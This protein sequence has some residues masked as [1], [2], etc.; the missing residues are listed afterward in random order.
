MASDATARVMAGAV[1]ALAHVLEVALEFQRT[2][3]AIL[4]T[5]AS[6]QGSQK[7]Q[8]R[9]VSRHDKTCDRPRSRLLEELE[10]EALPAHPEVLDDIPE[11]DAQGAHVERSVVWDD[12][13][14]VPHADR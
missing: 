8:S 2:P 9:G 3:R 12:G 5:R 13:V 10:G 7:R 14:M 1:A 4:L 11:H 6:K